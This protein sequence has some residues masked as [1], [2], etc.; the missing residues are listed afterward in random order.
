MST[1]RGNRTRAAGTAAILALAVAAGSEASGFES[2]MK[3]AVELWASPQGAAAS[4]GWLK[5]SRALM[6]AGSGTVPVAL[7]VETDERDGERL[8]TQLFAFPA[9]AA[10]P[11]AARPVEP[12]PRTS[13]R[14][15]PP[16]QRPFPSPSCTFRK[17]MVQG[18]CE[19][20]M[21]TYRVAVLLGP[22]ATDGAVMHVP[23]QQ[24]RMA[25]AVAA[26]QVAPHG[27]R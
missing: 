26:P 21:C 9:K 8:C 3:A 27:G 1:T 16:A 13:E 19:A 22:G 5:A 6:E 18:G 17:V 11:V 20:T 10:R 12:P 7:S 15:L 14:A 4:T 2:Y 24:V 23:E 25:V